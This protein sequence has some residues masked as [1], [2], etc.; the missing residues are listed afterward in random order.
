VLPTPSTTLVVVDHATTAFARPRRDKEFIIRFALLAQRDHPATPRR[1]APDRLV[2]PHHPVALAAILRCARPAPW[3]VSV[4]V[5]LGL[6]PGHHIGE[7][8]ETFDW[9]DHSA[10]PFGARAERRER[11]AWRD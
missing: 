11:G 9:N 6:N 7:R 2:W 5:A 3:F 4:A 1:N 10:P 8:L